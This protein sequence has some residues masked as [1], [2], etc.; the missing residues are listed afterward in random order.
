MGQKQKLAAQLL[1]IEAVQFRINEPFQWSSGILSP[2][3]C[4]TR[5]TISYPDIRTMITKNFKELIKKDYD[6]AQAIVGVATAGIPQAALVAESLDLPM[7]YV[8]AKPKEHGLENLIE[9]KIVKGQKVIVIEDVI[10]TGKSSLDAVKQL[11]NAGIEVLAVLA[12]FSYQFD[13][14]KEEFEKQNVQY[15]SLTNYNALLTVFAKKQ[16]VTEE[17]MASLHEWRKSPGTWKK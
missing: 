2:I 6:S 13:T 1:E 10:S 12:I 14:A 4:D 5:L 9:G 3:Y 11:Q 17:L 7:L 15:A 16:D 8:R